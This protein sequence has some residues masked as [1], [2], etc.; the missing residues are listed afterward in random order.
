MLQTKAN[1]RIE[2]LKEFARI[3][4]FDNYVG[5]YTSFW[6]S[7]TCPKWLQTKDC[8]T[9]VLKTNSILFCI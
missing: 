8:K 7:K 9:K 4:L 2:T 3:W 5:Q 1:S 6:Y